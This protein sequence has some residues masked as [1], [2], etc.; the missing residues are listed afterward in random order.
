MEK[1]IGEEFL[2]KIYKELLN[3]ELVQHTGKNK[4]R[5]EAIRQYM[6]RL[7]R[8][9]NKSIEHNKLS[10]LKTYYYDKYIIKKEN[11]SETYFKQQ[12][13]IALDR[14]YGYIKYDEK[15]K[16]IKINQIIEEQKSSL[17]SWIDYFTSTDTTIY[18]TWFKYFCFQGILR[19]GHYD[20]TQKKYTKRTNKTTKPFIEV[21]KEV[22]DMVYEELTKILNNQKINDKNLEELIKNGGFSKIYAYCIRKKDEIKESKTNSTEGIWKKYNEKSNPYIL[23]KD[24][25]GKGTG[26]CTALVLQTSSE[27]LESGD[28]YVY[29]TKDEKNEY[30][31]PRIAIRTEHDIIVEIRG[32][33]ENQNLESNMEKILDEKLNEFPDK[34]TYKQRI[35]DMKKITSIYKKW[36]K[37]KDFTPEELKFLYELEKPILSFGYEKDSRIKTILKN[38]NIKKDLSLILNCNEE[39]IS[40][41]KEETMQSTKL[42]HYGQ[43]EIIN[44]EKTKKIKLPETI[45][46]NLCISG[47]ETVENI[48]F[49]KKI[50]GDIYFYSLT[51]TNKLKLP[52]TIN[53]NIS[54]DSLTTPH[55]LEFSE[56]LNGGIYLYRVTETENIKFPNIVNGTVYLGALKKT[57]KLKLPETINGILYLPNLEDPEN[58]IIPDSLNCKLD[59][60]LANNDINILKQI[61]KE[62]NKTK[63]FSII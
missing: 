35:N 14:G 59:C 63:K 3:S 56:I 41:T 32:I 29:Y 60:P 25:Y 43:L 1:Y 37:D 49:P 44:Q 61:C 47:I 22:I 42:Y 9:T 57:N 39:D 58:I 6:E 16:Q 36:E 50:Y 48:E 8:V 46:G 2:N 11:I 62:K 31:C 4:N 17:D 10:L 54:F 13:Q 30:T 33:A 45:F 27:H 5:K 40:L 26:W 23:F 51:D 52:E 7:E 24:I 19:L 21:N 12:E 15:Q 28:F 38:R 55:K 20:K 18:P 34:E 53:G